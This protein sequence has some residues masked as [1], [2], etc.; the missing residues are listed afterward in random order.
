MEKHIEE[1]FARFEVEVSKTN[2]IKDEEAAKAE[3]TE[4]SGETDDKKGGFIGRLSSISTIQNLDIDKI[5]GEE[6]L[7][8]ELKHLKEV[9]EQIKDLKEEYKD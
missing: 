8:D 4:N 6:Y 1:L 5:M 9:G 3:K 7:V 2:N